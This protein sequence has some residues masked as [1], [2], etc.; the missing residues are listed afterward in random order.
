MAD[1]EVV[2]YRT[3][4]DDE[5]N[6]NYKDTEPLYLFVKAVE[7][8]LKNLEKFVNLYWYCSLPVIFLFPNYDEELIVAQEKIERLLYMKDLVTKKLIELHI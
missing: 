1:L 2:I 4:A 6:I 7:R 3:F 8:E 5:K